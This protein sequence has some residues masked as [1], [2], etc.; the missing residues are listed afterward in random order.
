[1][2]MVQKILQSRGGLKTETWFDKGDSGERVT[3]S[4]ADPLNLRVK[5][6]RLDMRKN[7]F[8]VRV[9]VHWNKISN[10]VRGSKNART[11]GKH[12]KS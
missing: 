3:S 11:S 2:S 1:M 10:I 8:S 7:F 12:I 4:T 6:G 5:H 9:I